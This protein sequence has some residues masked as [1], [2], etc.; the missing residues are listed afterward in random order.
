MYYVLLLLPLLLLL[1]LMLEYCCCYSYCYLLSYGD[2]VCSV[3]GGL[4]FRHLALG[5][6]GLRIEG[7]CEAADNLKDEMNPKR[8][9]GSY[10]I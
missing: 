8:Y 7:G 10:T 3:L 2:L 5:L 9:L 4:R 6:Q 1:L